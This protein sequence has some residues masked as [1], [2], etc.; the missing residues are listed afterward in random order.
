M[1]ITLTIVLLALATQFTACSQDSSTNQT[2]TAGVTNGVPASSEEQ[3][4]NLAENKSKAIV[5]LI[6]AGDMS[7]AKKIVDS[8]QDEAL[9]TLVRQAVARELGQPSAAETL[10]FVDQLRSKNAKA[11]FVTW[12]EQNKITS[13]GQAWE[14]LKNPSWMFDL[15]EMKDVTLDSYKL[16]LFGCD[17]AEKV[18]ECFERQH[19]TDKRPRLAIE[20]SRRF[21]QG[22][23]TKE[24]LA[25]AMDAAKATA[26]LPFTGDNGKLSHA[27]D[28][29]TDA[30]ASAFFT[31]DTFDVDPKNPAALYDIGAAYNAASNARSAA[32]NAAAFLKQNWHGGNSDDAT[33]AAAGS[34][35]KQNAADWQADRLRFYFPDPF[36]AK[37]R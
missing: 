23:A 26:S 36:N 14:K 24:E 20:T 8:I 37:P 9:K 32:Y 30:S 11:D 4:K 25:A 6:N 33:A 22:K 3:L 1:K 13:S 2:Q 27:D 31:A 29:S 18:L 5:N 10:T 28:A 16:R 19:P 17:C 35:A 7:G 34:A 12:V 15:A 21:A